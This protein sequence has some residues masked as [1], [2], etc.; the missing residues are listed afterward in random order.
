MKDR[1][2]LIHQEY[3]KDIQATDIGICAKTK[4]AFRKWANRTAFKVRNSQ[5]ILRAIQFR[6]LVDIKSIW[7]SWGKVI[8]AFK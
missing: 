1:Y 7:V 6:Q 8:L 2:N 3:L 5:N 4:L